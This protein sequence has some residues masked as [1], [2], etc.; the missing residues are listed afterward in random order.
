VRGQRYVQDGTITTTAGVTSGVFGALRLV[1][2]LAGAAEAQRVGRELGYPG[3]SLDGPTSIPAQRP[4]PRDLTSLLAGLAP[5]RRPAVGVGLAEGVGELDV[6]APFEVY[7]SSFAARTVPV[8]ARPTV[9]TRHG[10]RMVAAPADAAAPRVDRLIVPGARSLD[11]VDP[12]LAGWAAGRG[13]RVELPQADG[14]FS[15]DAMLRDLAAHA[16][17]TTA[18]VTAKSIEYHTGHLRLAGP[19]WPR[20]P[21]TAFALTLA[22]TIAAGFLPAAARRHRR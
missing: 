13:L 5:W 8:A 9:T 4:A 11:Q 22:A 10:L 15:F 2:Q 12:R 18:S 16:D 21:A 14:E 19:A 3:W 7:A 1:Q 17:R 20:R 6:A